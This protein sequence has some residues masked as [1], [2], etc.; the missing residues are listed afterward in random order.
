M[1]LMN[2]INCHM[3]KSLQAES[4]D[5]LVNLTLCS[6]FKRQCIDRS[7]PNC[8][9]KPFTDKVKSDIVL[10][11]ASLSQVVKWSRWKRTGL[12]NKDLVFRDSPL[13]EV[14]DML[15]SGVLHLA[16][17]VKVAEWLRHQYQE[18]RD[19]WPP[20]HATCT[21]DFAEIENYLCKFQNEIQSAHWSYRQ[22]TIH[23]CVFF[24][25]YRCSTSGC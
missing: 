11:D 2:V 16:K 3:S 25:F 9:V 22:V 6:R 20:G 24:F 10:R 8:G 12:M 21:V 18:L 15:E 5:E 19:N 14:L 17:H 23:P 13:D 1:L 7:C 4:V